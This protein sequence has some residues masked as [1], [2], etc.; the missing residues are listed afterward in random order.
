MREE[1]DGYEREIERDRQFKGGK[2]GKTIENVVKPTLPEGLFFVNG[3]LRLQTRKK[4]K[5]FEQMCLLLLSLRNPRPGNQ[6]D[7]K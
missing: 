4:S 5:V 2:K 3:F 1:R 6:V 7:V